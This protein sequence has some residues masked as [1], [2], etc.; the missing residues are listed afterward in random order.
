[1]LRSD[2]FC[3]HNHNN[4]NDNNGTDHFTPCACM[5]GN[6][7]CTGAIVFKIILLHFFFFIG[8]YQPL[9]RGQVGC[10]ILIGTSNACQQKDS[11]LN[12]MGIRLQRLGYDTCVLTNP[13]RTEVLSC[14]ISLSRNAISGHISTPIVFAFSGFGDE[15][16]LFFRDGQL[17][18]SEL[19]SILRCIPVEI[20]IM[21]LFDCIDSNAGKKMFEDPFW[22]NRRD[23]S[24]YFMKRQASGGFTL[25]DHLQ[26]Q[27][28]ASDNLA[29]I[30]KSCYDR[31]K[32]K[33]TTF[34][35]TSMFDEIK[36]QDL[37][38]SLPGKPKS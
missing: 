28:L 2:N 37:Q 35:Q 14:M 12:I 4:S 23:Y 6:D 1:M 31:F 7:V 9:L 10:A 24:V 15:E 22:G 30:V 34:G 26:M 8:Q 27:L 19:F 36:L 13:L 32:I 21:V 3:V 18:I 20:P 29:S 5:Q 38:N 33:L 25:F 11:S 16:S 17:S